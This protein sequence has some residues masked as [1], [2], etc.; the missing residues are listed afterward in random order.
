MGTLA[1]NPF[2]LTWNLSDGPSQKKF[3]S[4]FE[5]SSQKSELPSHLL[6][7]P[8]ATNPFDLT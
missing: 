8:I 7:G 5:L 6:M 3:D 4:P 2:D 1:T